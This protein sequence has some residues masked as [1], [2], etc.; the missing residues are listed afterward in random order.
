MAK[1]MREEES[2][3]KKK[4]EEEI[5]ALKNSY[6]KKKKPQFTSPT[7]TTTSPSTPPSQTQ[8]TDHFSNAMNAIKVKWDKKKWFTKSE[9]RSL[10]SRFGDIEVLIMIEP[11][12]GSGLSPCAVIS[13]RLLSSA[14]A[15]LRKKDADLSEFKVSW[16]EKSSHPSEGSVTST[17]HVFNIPTP[18]TPTTPTSTPDT[19]GLSHE[20]YEEDV[21]SRMRKKLQENQNQTTTTT[22]PLVQQGNSPNI[23]HVD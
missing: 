8:T 22:P 13:Y 18:T 9:L 7:P 15:A 5:E 3:S 11:K 4:L 23:I 2:V 14:E 20:K 21:F 1:Q 16:A 10:F 19:K 17:T 6:Q 12:L